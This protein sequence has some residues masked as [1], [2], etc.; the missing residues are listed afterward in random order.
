M[1]NTLLPVTGPVMV[2][3][4]IGFLWIK[5]NWPYDTD[6]IT[7]LV[8]CIGAPCLIVS[9]LTQSDI[10]HS[11]LQEMFWVT[12]S[13]IASSLLAAALLIRLAGQPLRTFLGPLVFPNAGNMG[14][15]VCLFAFGERG[16]VL[17]LAVF[18][19]LSLLHFTLGIALVSGRSVLRELVSNPIIYSIAVAI[20][21]LY[22]DY[23]L[24]LWAQNTVNLLG[25][26]T[27]PLMLLTL[28]VSL[29]TLKIQNLGKSLYFALTRLGIGV[30]AGWGMAEL[31]NLQGVARGVLI[32]QSAMPV[33]VFNYL[34]ALRYEREPQVVAGMVMISTLLSFVT[35]PVLILY[36]I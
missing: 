33:A 34:F 2:C 23:R 35:I 31:F 4:L 12:L 5:F 28:G 24:P 21:M 9:A 22:T 30:A 13:V 7:R 25:D 16:L 1:L 36:V 3:V 18:M 14:L 26:M 32:L 19:V 20:F 27:I 15:P 29:A 6:M 17:A 11:I 8:M 10:S